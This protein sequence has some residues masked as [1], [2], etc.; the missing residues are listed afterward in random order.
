[1]RKRACQVKSCLSSKG[2]FW[3]KIS[4]DRVVAIWCLTRYTCC[5]RRARLLK[6]INTLVLP[7]K[8][9]VRYEAIQPFGPLVQGGCQPHFAASHHPIHRLSSAQCGI[10]LYRANRLALTSVT[11]L[12][13][14]LETAPT[15]T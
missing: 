12:W 6:V 3:M 8:S 2:N 7:D 9:P 4:P 13:K 15:S 10:A 5:R 14:P 11:E 1:M